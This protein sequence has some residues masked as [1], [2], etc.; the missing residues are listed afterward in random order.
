MPWALITSEDHDYV[1][2]LDLKKSWAATLTAQRIALYDES[3]DMGEI[4][5]PTPHWNFARGV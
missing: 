1:F 2:S 3:G 5:S 4:V